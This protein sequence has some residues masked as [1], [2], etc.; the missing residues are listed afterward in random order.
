MIDYAN[1]TFMNILNIKYQVKDLF[2]SL[3]NE[4]YILFNSNYVLKD[5]YQDTANIIIKDYYD[6]KI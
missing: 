5:D 3:I 4:C 2:D 6:W 1:K